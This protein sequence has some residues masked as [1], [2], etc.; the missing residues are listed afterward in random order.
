[1]KSISYPSMASPSILLWAW[2]IEALA[3]FKP[4][5]T[6]LLQ[7]L[8]SSAPGIMSDLYANARE[9]VSLKLLEGWLDS[10]F[11]NSIDKLAIYAPPSPG[12][13]L[14]IDAGEKSEDVLIKV[15]RAFCLG[16]HGSELKYEVEQF[17]HHKRANLPAFAL[18]QPMDT[19]HED[20][21]PS[22]PDMKDIT[23]R[24]KQ[25]EHCCL[26]Q[27]KSLARHENNDVTTER[28][29]INSTSKMFWSSELSLT[30]G[31]PENM[32]EILTS[33]RAALFQQKI[34]ENEEVR[35]DANIQQLDQSSA[36]PPSSSFLREICG[37]AKEDEAHSLEN[38]RIYTGSSTEDESA[39]RLYVG[40]ADPKSHSFKQ[41]FNTNVHGTMNGLIRLAEAA[42][43]QNT[44]EIDRYN[45]EENI[46]LCNQSSDVQPSC[47]R[48]EVLNDVPADGAVTAFPEGRPKKFCI[49]EAKDAVPEMSSSNGLS[50]KG[51][52]FNSDDHLVIA[53]KQRFLSSQ[54]RQLCIK[55]EGGGELQT[56]CSSGCELAIHESCLCSS[57]SF[58]K[59]GK[60]YCPFCSYT[61]ANAVYRR[62]KRKVA[63]SRRALTDFIGKNLVD[64]CSGKNSPVT[65]ASKPRETTTKGEV[66]HGKTGQNGRK[67]SDSH[68]VMAVIEGMEYSCQ[69]SPC[70][71]AERLNCDEAGMPLTSD[72]HETLKGDSP[73][74]E[75]NDE[76]QPA[77]T[78]EPFCEAVPSGKT[79]MSPT[80]DTEL[81][82]PL[83]DGR[84]N[85]EMADNQQH[86]NGVE[87][88]KHDEGANLN[89]VH[90]T[91]AEKTIV[92]GMK[93]TKEKRRREVEAQDPST[94]SNVKMGVARS[95]S[96]E[97][98]SSY[99]IKRRAPARHNTNPLQPSTR[100]SKLLW[101]AEEEERL[102]EGVQK[103]SGAGGRGLPW[104][105][106][107]DYGS[108]IF[109]KTRTPVD[110]KDK[111]RN[112]LKN[113][114]K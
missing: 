51:T 40:T 5:D 71:E 35:N 61:R 64:G 66:S 110:L 24:A 33:R 36:A 15:A 74:K 54:K 63:L 21:H 81:I 2:V 65:S 76:D 101:T 68:I 112:I 30:A 60:F 57:V 31:V 72:R 49:F 20:N 69:K 67:T 96:E 86:S 55:C 8:L 78:L 82:V 28:H 108:H 85:V 39:T 22:A 38:H 11:D 52:N 7:A 6:D 50:D 13:R 37:S 75:G 47:K 73:H 32:N 29:K 19:F 94:S 17:I 4:A 70:R 53:E 43:Q 91:N 105:K 99:G 27:S 42:S 41:S 93:C 46:Q 9:R 77:R 25:D 109:H 79:G 48:V 12:S 59:S 56:C 44:N 100:R 106:I 107:L 89:E 104:I 34:S 111:W 58:D 18:D 114:K 14:A 26:D 97:E 1:M 92:A 16:K 98:G 95:G 83:K 84:G 45:T 87:D 3:D 62:A 90:K 80:S 113:V 103:L 23:S 10:N 102:K 88:G